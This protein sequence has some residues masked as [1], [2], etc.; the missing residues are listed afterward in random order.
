MSKKPK[1]N[2]RGGRPRIPLVTPDLDENGLSKKLPPKEIDFEAV[3]HWMDLG[4][5]AEEI[6]GAFRVGVRTLDR[7]LREHTGLGFGDLKEKACGAAKI[8]LRRN[9]FHLTKTNA[10]MGI[11]LGKQWLGQKDDVK[12]MEGFNGELKDFME[13]LKHKYGNKEGAGESVNQEASSQDLQEGDHVLRTDERSS[14]D[15]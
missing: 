2:S 3:L 12:P 5:T 6:A 4:A 13:F 14:E 7:R 10:A 1:E 9:Q 8:Q 11:W 15:D